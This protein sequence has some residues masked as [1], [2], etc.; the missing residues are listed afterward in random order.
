MNDENKVKLLSL[1]SDY[2]KLNNSLIVFLCNSESTEE[3]IEEA[4]RKIGYHYSFLTDFIKD[5]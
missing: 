1:L 2:K 5:L 4:S 3:D